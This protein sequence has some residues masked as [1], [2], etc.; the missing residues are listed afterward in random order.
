MEEIWLKPVDM[1]NIQLYI[2]ICIYISQGFIHVR[3]CSR[4]SSINSMLEIPKT[5]NSRS[6]I[7]PIMRMHTHLCVYINIKIY[8]RKTHTFM[9]LIHAYTPQSYHTSFF[10]NF[11]PQKST[12]LPTSELISSSSACPSQLDGEPVLISSTG[13]YLYIYTFFYIIHI[14]VHIYILVYVRSN[15]RSGNSHTN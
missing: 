2:Y 5:L 13:L 9:Q 15:P 8:L 12:T 6:I 7:H 3:W 1:V 11:Y 10:P 14:C 4:M